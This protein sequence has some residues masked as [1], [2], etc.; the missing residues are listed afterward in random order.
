VNRVLSKA[1]IFLLALGSLT[2]PAAE[3]RAQQVFRLPWIPPELLDETRSLDDDELTFCLNTDSVLVEFDRAVAQAITDTLLLEATFHEMVYPTAPYKYDFRLPLTESQLFVTITNNCDAFMGFRIT[4]DSIPDWLTVSRPYL[5]SR[6]IFVTT[7]ESYRSFAEIPAG[8]KIGVR[9]GGTGHRELRT[10]LQALPQGQRPSQ[11]P[12]PNNELLIER[13]R[14]GSVSAILVWEFA[15]Y[16]ATSGNVELLGLKT[17]FEPPFPV[18]PLQFS[19]TMLKQDTFVRG[20][21]DD[22]IEELISNGALQQITMEH[23]PTASRPG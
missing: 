11:V 19:A 3:I 6:M 17:S 5:E 4:P 14:D 18:P 7:N 12:Y 22:A 2:V 23:L 15:P 20:L 8:E 9:M 1:H 13:L 10:F 16:F 21:I